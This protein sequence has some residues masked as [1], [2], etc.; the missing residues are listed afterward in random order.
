M[1][2]LN[3][4]IRSG[5]CFCRDKDE[6]EHSGGEGRGGNKL[7]MHSRRQIQLWKHCW[8][9]KYQLDKHLSWETCRTTATS[10]GLVRFLSLAFSPRV[11]TCVY[12]TLTADQSVMSEGPSSLLVPLASKVLMKNHGGAFMIGS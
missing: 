4:S 10:R 8:C 1:A 3:K 6:Q 12:R 11:C 9:I 5:Y 7:E 2:S